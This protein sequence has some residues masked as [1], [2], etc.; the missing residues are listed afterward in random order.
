MI[1]K[2]FP[3]F[4]TWPAPMAKALLL[5]H[6]NKSLQ[7]NVL[8]ISEADTN[9][10][11]FSIRQSDL[12]AALH[13]RTFNIP[14]HR[15]LLWY[16]SLPNHFYICINSRAIKNVGCL[17]IFG[18]VCL[19]YLPST[20]KQGPIMEDDWECLLNMNYEHT[21]NCISVSKRYTKLSCLKY[22]LWEPPICLWIRH[23]ELKRALVSLIMSI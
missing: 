21:N 7:I 3:T 16:I 17:P 10:I 6:L 12:L 2:A 11:L 23:T 18:R 1:N 20:G 15:K 5:L 9:C 19:N 22:A 14:Q 4:F 8:P 13:N